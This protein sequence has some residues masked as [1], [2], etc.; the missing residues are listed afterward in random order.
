MASI[1]YRGVTI[2]ADGSPR[3][4]A[5]NGL[6]G[7]S[8]SI[9]ADT[10]LAD[11]GGLA[12][13]G[14]AQPLEFQL[15]LQLIG[16]DDDDRWGQLRALQEMFQPLA[17]GAEEPLTL[18]WP[19]WP[20]LQIGCAPV[21]RQAEQ[22]VISPL[23]TV[24]LVASDP[25]RYA[26]ELIETELAT[27][28]ASGGL[29]YPVEYPKDYGGVGEGTSTLVPND[30]TWQT[31]PLIEITGPTVGTTTIVSIENVSDG[32]DLLFTADDGLDI[33]AGSTLV[34]ETHP[35]RRSVAFTDGASR[36]NHVSSTEWWPIQPGGAL[37]RLRAT[38][39]TDGVTA[40]VRTRDAYL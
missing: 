35:A 24:Q 17:G 23:V 1:T 9:G 5:L 3:F 20:D 10:L 11:H 30:G 32:V 21:S 28:V 39:D 36:W 15:V 18:D 2:E 40:T 29:E 13:T 7:F 6:D 16:D 33:G 26:T 37:L 12:R 14:W 25:V 38:G 27:F 34:I 22:S 19:G 4:K 31:W 8:S